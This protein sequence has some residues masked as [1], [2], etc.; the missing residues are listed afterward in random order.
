MPVATEHDVA[1]ELHA[2]LRAFVGRRIS[3]PHAADDIAQEV[4]LRLH[5][6]LGELRADDRLDAFAYRIARNAVIDHYRS[7]ARVKEAALPP[8]GVTARIDSDG[9]VGAEPDAQR[10]RQELA[11]C[12]EPIIRRL[13]EPYREA[14]TLTDLGDLT[15]AEAAARAGVTVPGMK[16]RVQRARAQLHQQLTSCCDVML[17]GRRGIA[18]VERKG[19]CA[20]SPAPVR[21]ASP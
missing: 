3:D 20:C 21:T 6:S 17:D 19:P 2:R 8:E 16:S 13:P 4:L 9:G 14:L 1:A 18:D 11:R 12:L 15:Q 7:R 5:R 10:G